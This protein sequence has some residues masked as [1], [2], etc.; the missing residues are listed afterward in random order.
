MKKF[1]LTI[2]LLC[3]L[4]SY[5]QGEA[6]V[7][8]FG[9]NAGIDF[10][11]GSPSALTNGNLN[12]REG[13]STFSKNNG[14]LLFYSDGTTI[15]NK[16]HNPMPNGTGLAG[17][18]SSTQSAMIIPIPTSTNLYYLFTVGSP[19]NGGKPGFNYYTVD[20]NADGGLGDIINGPIDLTDDNTDN[21]SEKVA[22]IKG[23]E[24]N[25]YW[26]LSYAIDTFYAYKITST[27]VESP[28]ISTTNY[29]ALDR[30]GY[31]KISPNGKK[32]AIA[33]MNNNSN[34]QPGGSLFL[35]DFDKATGIVSSKKDLALIAPGNYPYGV[36]FSSSSEKLY[37]HASNDFWSSDAF[38]YNN[39]ANHISTLYQFNLSSNIA[40][41]INSS[42][43]IIDSQNLFR[44]GL[45]L[46]PDQK[47]YRALS[48]TYNE[49]IPFLGVIENPEEDGVSCNYQHSNIDLNGNNST[50][51]LPPFI[52]SIFSQVEIIG[53]DSNSSTTILNNQTKHLCIG[54]N[55]T[56]VPEALTGIITYNWYFNN[57]SIPFSD[58]ETISFS[59]ATSAINGVY[60]LV[61]T[62]TDSCNITSTLEGDFSIEVH[63]PP[64][65]NT[66]FTLKQCD[67]DGIS[68]GTTDFNL[69]EATSF[70]TLGDN[71]LTTTYY[72][73]FNDAN[74]GLN[75][76]NASPFSN[77]N[78]SIVWARIES[79]YGCYSIAEVNL[80]VSTTQLSDNYLKIMTF[81]D[82][83]TVDDGLYFVDLE[84]NSADII[85]QFPL[86]QNLSVSYYRT[87][88]DAQLEEN[89]I[90]KNEPYFNETPYNQTLYVRVE[91]ND[92][93]ACFGIGPHLKLVINGKPE[94][95]IDATAI[96]CQ[97]LKP[98]TVTP[99][100]EL[101]NYTYEWKDENGGIISNNRDAI[102]TKEGEYS[103]IATSQEGCKSFT[104]TIT[105]EASIIATLLANDITVI[106]DSENNSITISTTNLGIGDYE[107]AIQKEN[108]FINSYQDEPYFENLTPGFYTIF[109]R[110]KNNCGTSHIEA[111]IIGFPKFFTPNNDGT[112]D[113]WVILGT[114][115]NFYANSKIY[116]FDR[117]GKLLKQISPKSEGW[118]GTFN[119]YQLPET[120]Y[121]FSAELIDSNGN[122]RTRKGHFSL[123]RR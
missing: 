3:S 30:R 17:H 61:V 2:T 1:I 96:Y 69:N 8:Y 15:W 123:I 122:I 94:F 40:S 39:P 41:Q 9:E 20:M 21:W 119:G 36:E 71:T 121:W 12:T 95:E 31:L 22:A 4:Y 26:V 10:N 56:V 47:I 5:A 106:D 111:S 89:E 105:I 68:D 86:A 75:P 44:G 113:T 13:C 77:K 55:L 80:L 67:E 48:K 38:Q 115:E 90:P 25:T 50:Q 88:V 84:Q 60:K 19:V 118:N 11:S 87:L 79:I 93:G 97:N 73:T 63:N 112:N 78:Q 51:G 109:V 85:N 81:C 14:E 18:S 7:W 76:I 35:Y 62:Q 52:A 59:N 45:Q 98:I 108:E 120:D 117:F 33:H 92:N 27:N 70:L 6:N 104:K 58:Q 23:E 99:Y 16:N 54:D 65:I 100:N 28:I 103:V 37:V 66:T 34:T 82:N 43:V 42:R 91:S 74:S 32:I 72:A 116:I 101:G 53:N 29:T 46:G 107:F 102:I 114:N 64:T 24:C 110:D 49:G 83:D 57:N